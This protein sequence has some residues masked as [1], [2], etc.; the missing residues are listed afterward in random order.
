MRGIPFDIIQKKLDRKN[1]EL[2]NVRAMRKKLADRER[3]ICADIDLKIKSRPI[4]SSGFFIYKFIFSCI[5][6]LSINHFLLIQDNPT[7]TEII[8]CFEGNVNRNRLFY[9]SL[10]TTYGECRKQL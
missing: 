5:I 3:Q 9:R 10:K 1:S 2:A 7:V 6:Y 8:A 4:S